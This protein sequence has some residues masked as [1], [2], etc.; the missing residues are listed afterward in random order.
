[1][2]GERGE[3][4]RVREGGWRDR[5]R[6]TDRERGGGREGG[7]G[8][9][10]RQRDRQRERGGREGRERRW[11]QRERGGGEW[12]TWIIL[13][14]SLNIIEVVCGFLGLRKC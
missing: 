2:R 10:E 11:M 9:M 8:G 13:C 14:W 12:L 3:E 5:E 7:A 6:Q 4:E 1:M